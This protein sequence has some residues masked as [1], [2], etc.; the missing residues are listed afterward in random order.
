M[1]IVIEK[2]ASSAPSLLLPVYHSTSQK[3]PT[4]RDWVA[5]WKYDCRMIAVLSNIPDVV[6]RVLCMAS[7]IHHSLFIIH[8]EM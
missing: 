6:E 8:D 5:R 7:I 4:L 2:D 1:V 3:H